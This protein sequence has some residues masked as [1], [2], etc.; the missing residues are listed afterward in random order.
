MVVFGLIGW[1][2]KPAGCLRNVIQTLGM[3]DLE[4]N[5]WEDNSESKTYKVSNSDSDPISPESWPVKSV[6]DNVLK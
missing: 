3:I 2:T 4:Y 6:L 5:I 1:F